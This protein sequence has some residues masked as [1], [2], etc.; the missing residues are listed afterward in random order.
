MPES[1]DPLADALLALSASSGRVPRICDGCE[2]PDP[3]LRKKRK[4]SR[5]PP[6]PRLECP[7]AQSYRPPNPRLVG[8]ELNPGP[9]PPRGLRG[10]GRSSAASAAAALAEGAVAIINSGGIPP[11]KVKKNTP[12]QPRP[13]RVLRG[14]TTNRFQLGG[15]G[16]M[17]SN[18]R[19]LTNSVSNRDHVHRVPFTTVGVPLFSSTGA[20]TEYRWGSPGS[21]YIHLPLDPNEP[22]PYGGGQFMYIF[23]DAFVNLSATY[24][25]YRLLDLRAEWE[26]MVGTTEAAAVALAYDPDGGISDITAAATSATVLSHDGAVATPAWQKTRMR[27]PALN[28]QWLFTSDLSVANA[29]AERQTHAGTILM[30]PLTSASTTSKL[31]GYLSFTGVVEFKGLGPP[32]TLQTFRR[33]REGQSAPGLVAASTSPAPAAAATLSQVDLSRQP[34]LTGWIRA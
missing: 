22:I 3:A 27:L 33:S 32:A 34:T 29:A 17:V 11:M 2:Y 13:N 30:S 1:S 16:A 8:I 19:S 12:P 6:S 28:R 20:S 25:Q 10:L 26:P 4:R 21:T 24:R 14:I 23:G 5:N 9:N 18:A 31:L 15:S 7:E